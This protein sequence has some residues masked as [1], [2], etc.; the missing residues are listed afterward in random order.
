MQYRYIDKMDV[1]ETPN[2][3]GSPRDLSVEKA[4]RGYRSREPEGKKRK[5][6]KI[7]KEN[8]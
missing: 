5:E 1:D 3:A 7:I 8:N 2:Y 4:V 6:K